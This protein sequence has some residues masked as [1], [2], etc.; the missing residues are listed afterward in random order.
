MPRYVDH[1]DRR[2]EILRATLEVLA[3]KGARGLTFRAVAARMGGSSTL[4]THYFASRQ[5]LLDNLAEVVADWPAEVA[6]LETGVDDPAER[7]RLFL[8]WLVPSSEEGMIAERGRINMIGEQD[9]RVRTQHLFDTWDRHVRDHLRRHVEALVPR[10]QVDATV[11]LLRSITNGI[12]LS[13]VEHP[14]EWPQQRQFAV[15][16]DALDRLGLAPAPARR[17]RARAKV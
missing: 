7:L 15:V 8:R 5:A 3:E 1:D 16:D 10:R 14:A 9:A 11:D 17:S 13:A 6:E 12:T 2:A 4:V